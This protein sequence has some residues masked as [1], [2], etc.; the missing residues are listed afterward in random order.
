MKIRNATVNDLAAMLVLGRRMH[1]ESPR[2][3]LLQYDEGKVSLL[4]HTALD[5]NAYFLMVAE[6]ADGQVIGGLIAYIAPMWFSTDEVASELA[7]FIDQDRRGGWAAIRL[8]RE[9]ITWAAGMGAKQTVAGISTGIDI[10]TTAQLYRAAGFK[11]VGHLF[12]V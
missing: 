7:L 9:F 12:E 2:F 3:N 1:A 6:H 4:L 8:L 11:Q 5:S 10:D